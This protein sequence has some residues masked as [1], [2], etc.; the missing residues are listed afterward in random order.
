MTYVLHRKLGDDFVIRVGAADVRLRFVAA[1]SD[2][3]FQSA[4]LM[5]E[6]NFLR[7]FPAQE[8]Y[9]Q[10]LAETPP[11]ADLEQTASLLEDALAAYGADVTSTADRLAE[12]HRVE[13][14]YL[15]T[16]QLLGGLGLLLGTVGLAAILL[17]S[18]LERRR[19]LAL[20]RVLGYAERQ[21]LAIT[22]L[23]SAS[24]LVRGLAIGAVCAAIAIAPAALERGGQLPV[25]GLLPL[26]AAILGLG[27]LV[28]L[29]AAKVA[30]RES[31]L[32]A[33]R[34]E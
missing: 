26:F 32:G 27:L 19:E 21:L 1:L 34:S 28:A 4:L 25:V 13:N 24:V 29:L 3:I 10:L 11:A 14:T 2:S 31:T 18:V 20:L 12:F 6:A 30:L 17:R 23:E 5:S 16:F 9:T 7:L 33:L 22:V 8:G 15:S